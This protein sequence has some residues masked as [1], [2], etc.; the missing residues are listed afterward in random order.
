MNEPKLPPQDLIDRFT[1][2]LKEF[3]DAG[4]VLSAQIGFHEPKHVEDLRTSNF[5]KSLESL[6][7]EVQAEVS[8]VIPNDK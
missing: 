2:L 8:K 1:A 7:P 3:N 4:F 5:K 6:P